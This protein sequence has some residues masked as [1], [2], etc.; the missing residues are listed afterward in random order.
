MGTRSSRQKPLR[1]MRK[2]SLT[3]RGRLCR[4]LQQNASAPSPPA[5]PKRL[6]NSAHGL[7]RTNDDKRR[8]VEMLLSDEEWSKR[9]DRWIAEKCGVHHDTVGSYRKQLSVSASSPGRTGQ[10]GK[11]RK[12]PE[13]K[14]KM[15]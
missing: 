3:V 10:D 8:A 13:R 4:M 5:P 14:P 2:R 1:L 12:L 11:T 6:A 9:S 7:R 15:E